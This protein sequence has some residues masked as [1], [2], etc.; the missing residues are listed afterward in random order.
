MNR[1]TL[2]QLMM[3]NKDAFAV[4]LRRYDL[5][6]SI[7]YIQPVGRRQLSIYTGCTER[8]VRSDSD[9]LR[10]TGLV[11][12]EAAGIGGKGHH[13]CPPCC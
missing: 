9:A 11:R 12:S 2:N 7:S 4:I 13:Q 10:L 5:L 8:E 3:L 6:R 1:S